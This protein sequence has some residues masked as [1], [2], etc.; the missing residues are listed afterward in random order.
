M[1]VKK[2]FYITCFTLLGIV[3]SFLVHGAVEIVAI[4]LLVSDFDRYSLGLSWG[5]WVTI[6]NVAT[7]VLLVLFTG[8]GFQQGS[9]W[10]NR[11]YEGE[12]EL[13]E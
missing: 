2:Y 13:F 4:D 3:T 12:N 5:Q 10:W 1:N 9:Y 8:I 11:L 7:I 6:H